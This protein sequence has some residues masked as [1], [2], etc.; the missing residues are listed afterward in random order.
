MS[1]NFKLYLVFG[2]ATVFLLILPVWG[3][4]LAL[5]NG[6]LIKGKYLGGT[7]SEIE[8]R[9]G[10]TVQHYALTDV[11]SITFEAPRRAAT[12]SASPEL[13]PRPSQPQYQ[14]S[15]TESDTRPSSI[16][17]PSGTRLTV[18]MIDAI[19]SDSNQAGDKFS[20]TMEQPLI[21]DAVTVVPKGAD[22]Y[23]RLTEAKEAGHIQ[24][25]SELKLELT[26]IVVNGQTIPLTTGEYSVA[27]SS[28][29]ASS[30]KRVGGGAAVGAVIGALA[31]GGKGAAIGAGVGAGAG[32]AVQVITKGEQVHVP[33]ETV[34]EFALQQDVRMPIAN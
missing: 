5:K 10:S 31:G 23:G 29:G 1:K 21:V 2:V 6:S 4:S 20:A 13:A 8:F 7:E 11:V 32:T 28:R 9:V 34:L 25:R 12:S 30:A 19:D 17:V 26:G 14:S 16:K 33:S 18:R 15:S 3:D 22:V 24:G 27:G